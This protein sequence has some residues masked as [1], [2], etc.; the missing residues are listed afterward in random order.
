MMEKMELP[1]RTWAD[2]ILSG[3]TEIPGCPFAIEPGA[4]KLFLIQEIERHPRDLSRDF[5]EKPATGWV[6]L[7]N[8]FLAW[9]PLVLLC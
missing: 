6:N 9:C 5:P 4:G 3:V 7:N 1:E 8:E 2:M